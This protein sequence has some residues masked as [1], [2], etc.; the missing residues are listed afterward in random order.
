[1]R[2]PAVAAL[3]VAVALGA[4]ATRSAD[5]PA[6]AADPAPAVAETLAGVWELRP[7]QPGPQSVRL[8]VRVDSTRSGYEA[9]LLVFFSGHMGL[10]LDAFDVALETDG[11][12]VRLQVIPKGGG[13]PLQVHGTRVGD[14]IRVSFFRWGVTDYTAEQG[15]VWVRTRSGA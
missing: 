11:A 9:R 8:A 4:C 10:D 6:P 14:A 3:A 1:M 12:V 13:D 5:D 2:S 15:W 7:E